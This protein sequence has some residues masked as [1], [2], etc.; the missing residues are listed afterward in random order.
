M[1]CNLTS[2][3]TSKLA[4][5]L[6]RGWLVGGI[7]C[8]LVSSSARGQQA[9]SLNAAQIQEAI[10]A[11]PTHPPTNREVITAGHYGVKIALVHHRSGPAELHRSEDRVMYVLSGEASLCSGGTMQTPKDISPTEAQAPSLAGCTPTAMAPGT[12][13]SIPRGVPYQLR[14]EKTRVEF[15]VVRIAG[16]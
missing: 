15:I 16:Q 12:V 3:F 6:Y 2:N 9:V 8:L 14:A 4:T 11:L 5:V 7:L 10:Q 13:I 1:R